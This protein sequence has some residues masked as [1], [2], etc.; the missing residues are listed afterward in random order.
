MA[1]AHVGIAMGGE[2]EEDRSWSEQCR[3][4]KRK[5]NLSIH[6]S[7]KRKREKMRKN[8]QCEEYVCLSVKF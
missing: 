2:V 4:K 7:W 3:M 1:V 6:A 8:T 5:G